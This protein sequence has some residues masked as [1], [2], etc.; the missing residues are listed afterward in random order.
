MQVPEGWMYIQQHQRTRDI[1]R[2]L[3]SLL[4]DP[5]SYVRRAALGSISCLISNRS[6]EGMIIE[7]AP[8]HDKESLKYACIES[9]LPYLWL[10]NTMPL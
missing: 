9:R 1:A 4:Y 7:R 10:L 5:E 8:L 2:K 3:P 6:C